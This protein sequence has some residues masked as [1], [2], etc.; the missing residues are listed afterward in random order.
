M[1]GVGGMN[2]HGSADARPDE[3]DQVLRALE[4]VHNPKSNNDLRQT[5]SEYLERIKTDKEA[6]YC[7]FILAQGR[8]QPPVVRHFGLGLLSY[9]IRYRWLDHTDNELTALRGWV[10]ELAQSVTAS[11]PLYVRNKIA[12]L[13]VEM[14]KRSWLVEWIN[15]D[16]LLFRLWDGSITQRVLVLTILETLSEDIFGREDTAAA[17]R[18][19]ELSRA[20]VDIFTPALVLSESFPS[21][22]TSVDVRYGEDGWLAR[23]GNL[24]DLCV[25]DARIGQ[26]C[27]VKGLFT[28]KSVASWV[29][30]KALVATKSLERI[31]RCLSS[32]DT[33]VQLVCIN[34]KEAITNEY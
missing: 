4:V 10:L 21:R 20:C 32:R 22:E 30:P 15:M 14:A 3:N 25:D 1:N 24:M 2:G 12:E 9:T 6:P 19:T 34:S 27:A 33:A 31:C 5:A 17:L 11:D 26:A 18:G 7:G 28:L 8:S 29:V 23:V 16:E 13:W